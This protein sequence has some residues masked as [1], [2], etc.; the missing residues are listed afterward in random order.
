MFYKIVNYSLEWSNSI[1]ILQIH[2]ES[3]LAIEYEN[4]INS[5]SPTFILSNIYYFHNKK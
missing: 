5:V 4:K 2:G 1:C 3:S